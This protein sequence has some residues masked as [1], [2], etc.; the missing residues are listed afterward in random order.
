MVGELRRR[1]DDDTGEHEER[2]EYPFLLEEVKPS[3]ANQQRD[4]T[5]EE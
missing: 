2:R 1:Q 5:E 4:A 3:I